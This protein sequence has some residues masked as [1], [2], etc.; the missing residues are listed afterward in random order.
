MPGN[1]ENMCRGL[2]MRRTMEEASGG[3]VTIPE[4]GKGRG[5]NFSKYKMVLETRDAAE[6]ICM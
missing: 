6:G 5:V 1:R 4:Q 3:P 2:K